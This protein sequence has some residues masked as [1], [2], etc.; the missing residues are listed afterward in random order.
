MLKKAQK[1]QNSSQR[2]QARSSLG[3]ETL[4]NWST[5]CAW[6]AYT[7]INKLEHRGKLWV[8]SQ[9]FRR[10][11]TREPK[12]TK[13]GAFENQGSTVYAFMSVNHIPVSVN[14]DKTKGNHVPKNS[15]LSTVHQNIFY[16]RLLTIRLKS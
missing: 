1:Q 16:E 15:Y 10:N 3:G 11:W 9:I 6:L 8:P 7:C 2:I 4:V 12:N 13:T 14:W 5:S